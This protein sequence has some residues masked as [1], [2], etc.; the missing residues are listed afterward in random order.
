[1]FG[2]IAFM[3]DGK[4]CCGVIED[5]LIVRVGPERYEEAL[6]EPHVRPM[7]FTGRSLRGFV[8]VGPDGYRKNEALAK[9]VRQAAD[10]ARSL[11]EK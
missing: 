6:S 1:M 9:W 2:G 5:D 11:L 7:D 10:F 4:M 8:F 3:L